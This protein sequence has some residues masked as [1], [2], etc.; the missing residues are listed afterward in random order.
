MNLAGR[1][2]L[3][4]AKNIEELFDIGEIYLKLEGANPYGN[5]YDRIAEHLIRDT[6]L[7]NKKGV[8]VDG[9]KEYIQSIVNF[10]ALKNVK[11]MIPV[12][13][14]E[15]FKRKHWAHLDLIDLSKEPVLDHKNWMI[16]YSLENNLY[17]AYNGYSNKN[18]SMLALEQIGEE[19]YAKFSD[20]IDTIFVQLDY[21]YTLAGIYN[22]FS[23]KYVS[24]ECEKTPAII[25]CTIPSG[26]IIYKKYLESSCNIDDLEEYTVV[27]NKYTKNMLIDNSEVLQE[28]LDAVYD[29]R[30]KIVSIDE[31]TLITSA[32]ILR[33]KEGI[34][35]STK[36]TYSFAGLYQ[37]ALQGKLKTGKHI[38]IL[39]DGKSEV[40]ILRITDTKEYSIQQ[41]I[42]FVDDFLQQ[43]SDS[44]MEIKN[45]IEN[46]LEKG[47][48]FLAH[49]NGEVQG[50]AIVVNTGFNYFIPTYHLGYIGTKEGNKGRGIASKLI[51][52][53]ISFSKGNISLHVDLTNKRAKK[54]YEKI[55]FKHCYNRMIYQ[56]DNS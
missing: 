44:E 37:M 14:H 30:G 42:K 29:T 41:L 2:P 21:D 23:R 39:N 1:T 26:N 48:V 15:S 20:Q 55:G 45:A 31:A 7:K 40:N 18:V 53:V 35:V 8:L 34:H 17:N 25:S 38:V 3:F 24:G 56:N 54:L 4:R 5:K 16:N 13:E 43:Y 28:S 52:E 22:S 9:T 6:E 32:N 50:I 19:L 12:F 36:E 47:Q 33:I 11:V 46:A 49:R 10:A 51:D 27:A